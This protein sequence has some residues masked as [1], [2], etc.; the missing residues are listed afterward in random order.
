MPEIRTQLLLIVFA[1]NFRIIRDGP[2][3]FVPIQCSYEY[4]RGRTDPLVIKSFP[5]RSHQKKTG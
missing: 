4:L 3:Y 1:E 5:H 2:E